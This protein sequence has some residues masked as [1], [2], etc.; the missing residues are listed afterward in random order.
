MVLGDFK[1]A[2]LNR[3]SVQE[4]CNYLV[5]AVPKVKPMQT[6]ADVIVLIAASIT[7]VTALQPAWKWLWRTYLVRHF[8][9]KKEHYNELIEQAK[10]F[11]NRA[12]RLDTLRKQLLYSNMYEKPPDRF[13]LAEMISKLDREDAEWAR[14]VNG[15]T[16]LI[17]ACQV[18]QEECLN[19][20]EQSRQFADEVARKVLFW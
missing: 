18:K 7:L 6:K 16:L 17:E 8:D 9:A 3:N 4:V 5:Q 20:S 15:A 13:K 10:W 14:K 1:R 2:Y 11:E 12:M 19:N